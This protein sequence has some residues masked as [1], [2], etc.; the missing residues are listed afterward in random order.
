MIRS[1]TSRYWQPRSHCQWP[2]SVPW[3]PGRLT[4]SGSMPSLHRAFGL[5]NCLVCRRRSDWISAPEPR[6]RLPYRSPRKSSR[7]AGM[8]AAAR[9]PRS[10]GP[11]ITSLSRC[12]A[13]AWINFPAPAWINFLSMGQTD[14]SCHSRPKSTK[15]T[16]AEEV[17][18]CRSGSEQGRND[19]A[20]EELLAGGVVRELGEVDDRVRHAQL[21]HRRKV[22][23]DL[24]RSS[25]TGAR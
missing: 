12:P 21:L 13:L 11:S 17:D 8:A 2:T 1:S 6:R 4:R 3:A 7:D 5:N 10:S 24:F 19:F 15:L 22:L 25:D 20:L 16:H 18:P 9:S 14:D 23:H